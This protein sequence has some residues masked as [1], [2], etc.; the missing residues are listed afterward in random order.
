MKTK[1]KR[2]EDDPRLPDFTKGEWRAWFGSRNSSSGSPME[3]EL[4]VYRDGKHVYNITTADG[5]LNADRENFTV[6]AAAPAMLGHLFALLCNFPEI[7]TNAHG[8]IDAEDLKSWLEEEGA[9]M[10]ETLKK[11]GVML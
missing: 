6:M 11:A 3:S 2:D 10:R 4:R 1:L 7:G 9:Y 8:A 5:H